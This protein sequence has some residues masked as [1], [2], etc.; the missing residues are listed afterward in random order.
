MTNTIYE[1]PTVSVEIF[2]IEQGFAQS[3][4]GGQTKLVPQSARMRITSMTFKTAETMKRLIKT[5][6]VIA[7]V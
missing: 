2:S 5:A 3:N 4:L 6:A 7:S 1:T